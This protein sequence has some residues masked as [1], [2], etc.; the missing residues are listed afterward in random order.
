MEQQIQTRFNF[1]HASL[2]S[3]IGGFDLAAQ[4]MGWENVFHCEWN[5]FCQQVLKYYWPNS[6]SFTDITKTDFT[7]Y[8]NTIDILTGGFPCQPYSVAGKRKGKEDERHLWPEMLRAIR[9]IQP[10]WV[11]GENVSGIINWNGGM[12]FEEVQ[13]DLEAAGYE[14]QSFVLPACGVDAP[15]RRDRVWFVAHANHKRSSTGFGE[16]QSKNG[17]ISQWNNNAQFGN[18]GAGI[19]KNTNSSGGKKPKQQ[20]PNLPTKSG[21]CNTETFTNAASNRR[22][23]NGQ[24]FEIEKGLQPRPESAGE[25]ERGFEGLCNTGN[26]ADTNYYHCG[27]GYEF[28][29]ELGKY[30]CPNCEG[31]YEAE[32]TANPEAIGMEGSRA[33]RQQELRTHEEQRLF[34]RHSTRTNWSEWPTQPPICS[35][36]DGISTRLDGITFPK[37][38]NESIKSYG[39]AV[40]PQ[41]VLQIFKSIQEYENTNCH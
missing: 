29:E 10:T 9:E 23:R 3:G 8:A 39:N 18:A 11:V 26:V 21:G 35:R 1:K 24:G 13:A 36:D 17:K 28:D 27:C 7:K 6:E 12:V 41:V 37:W 22:E 25:L 31:E 15:H 2:F 33:D 30:G 40:V 38:R 20:Q 5:P 19:V 34:V 32:L 14:V 16:V 4:Q